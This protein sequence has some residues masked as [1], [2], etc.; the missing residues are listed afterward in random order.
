M[1][2]LDLSPN[3]YEG[4]TQWSFVT[5]GATLTYT[6]SKFNNLRSFL[7][8]NQCI[9][10]DKYNLKTVTLAMTSHKPAVEANPY[11]RF[12]YSLLEIGSHT[13]GQVS[14]SMNDDPINMIHTSQQSKRDVLN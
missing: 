13:Q 4:L 6:I 8:A 3:D 1:K 2:N 14:G 12:G 9:D 5:L 7:E 11:V 10:Y